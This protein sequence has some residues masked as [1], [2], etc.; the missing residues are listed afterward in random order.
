MRD[1]LPMI[2]VIGLAVFAMVFIAWIR[3]R[4]DAPVSDAELAAK[5]IESEGLPEP[6]L[7]SPT[8]H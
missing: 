3:H 4:H 6:A 1:N 8:V 2:L 5:I 7:K